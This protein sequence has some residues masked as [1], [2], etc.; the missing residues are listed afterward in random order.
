[1]HKKVASVPCAAVDDGR[2]KKLMKQTFTIVNVAN[3]KKRVVR[4][5]IVRAEQVGYIEEDGVPWFPVVGGYTYTHTFNL[6]EAFELITSARQ[7]LAGHDKLPGLSW[8]S[9]LKQST[10][11]A[12]SDLNCGAQNYDRPIGPGEVRAALLQ[13][14]SEYKCCEKRISRG[15]SQAKLKHAKLLKSRAKAYADALKDARTA[16]IYDSASRESSLTWITRDH[17]RFVWTAKAIEK[18]LTCDPVMSEKSSCGRSNREDFIRGPLSD[19]YRRLF[20]KKAGWNERG[21][22]AR[23]GQSFFAIIGQPIAAGTI[24]RAGKPRSKR[25]SWRATL[26]RAVRVA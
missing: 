4:G 18:E 12:L 1:M 8:L 24:A 25:P 3:A 9:E 5:G 6:D 21:P 11:Q 13:L 17:K 10:R 2:Q 20:G 14:L 19:C 22:F 26:P 23:F 16:Q 7:P 15:L